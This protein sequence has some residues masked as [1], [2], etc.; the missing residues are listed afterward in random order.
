MPVLTDCS[1]VTE[2]LPLVTV[3]LSTRNGCAV[4]A[5]SE[6]CLD[7]VPIGRNRRRRNLGKGIV[8][9]RAETQ[10]GPWAVLGLCSL[11]PGRVSDFPKP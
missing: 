8:T 5:L 4:K 7:S 11:E 2:G 10:S 3:S 6:A 1:P 9:R